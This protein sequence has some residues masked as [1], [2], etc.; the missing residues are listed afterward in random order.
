[1]TLAKDGQADFIHDHPDRCREHRSGILQW[2][3]E[4]GLNSKYST[5]GK[6]GLRAKGAGRCSVDGRSLRGY[7][8]VRG[9]TG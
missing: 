5:G 3:R 4:M 9:F 8:C 1:M 6:W 7:M 2:G